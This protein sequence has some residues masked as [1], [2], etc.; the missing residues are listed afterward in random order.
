MQAS[1][2]KRI[3]DACERFIYEKSKKK[4]EMPINK[5]IKTLHRL[6][7][8]SE[9]TPDDINI[10]LKL[11]HVQRHMRLHDV[12]GIWDR[13]LGQEFGTCVRSCIRSPMS[14]SPSPTTSAS[15]RSPSKGARGDKTCIIRREEMV[16][17]KSCYADIF[18][19]F[20]AC[21][22]G[23]S[24]KIHVL[25]VELWLSLLNLGQV[26]LTDNKEMHLIINLDTIGNKPILG[27]DIN[28]I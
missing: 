27:E 13:L 7:L 6:D 17:A 21:G 1:S 22:H 19:M 20:I 12:I 4:I 26:H 14:I 11:F 23:Y 28:V 18:F 25:L 8:V 24:G 5:A 10:K 3:M 9:F 16:T 15:S 2:L